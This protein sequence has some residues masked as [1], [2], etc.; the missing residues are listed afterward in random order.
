MNSN[1]QKSTSVR[2]GSLWLA[3]AVVAASVASLT[4]LAQNQ[5]PTAPK[6]APK[7]PLKAAPV[8]ASVRAAAPRR[9]EILFLG[10]EEGEHSTQ[11]AT[12][13]FVPALAKEGINVSW[14]DDVADLTPS[15]LG[16]YD[17]LMVYGDF[18]TITPAEESAV[19]AYVNGGHGLVAIHSAAD[20]FKGTPAWGKLI[21]AQLDRHGPVSDI[22]VAVTQ[23]QHPVV[24]EVTAFD[25]KDEP[26]FFKNA[27]ADR[28]IL[29]DRPEGAG[30]EAV[31]WAR[32]QGKGR[33][34]YTALGHDEPT[35]KNA[36][37]QALIRGAALWTAGDAVSN[38]W[39][40]LQM[41]TVVYKPSVYIPNYERRVPPL[42]F[43]EPLS[44]QDSMKTMQVPPGFEVKLFASEPDIIKPIS[45]NWDERGRLWVVES[46]D[47][48]N[49]QIASPTN[50]NN[51]KHYGAH[52]KIVICEDTNGDGK[53]DK[54][55]TFAEGL[56]IPTGITFWNG[57]V[58]VGQAPQML[59][60]KDT[61]GD[62]K[63]DVRQVLQ[64]GWGLRDTHSG[65][66]N[67]RYGFDNYIWGSIGYSG[68][69]GTTPDGKTMMFS[70]G[71]F[72]MHPDGTGM[73]FMGAF[74][75][76]TWGLGFSETFDL[77]GSTANNTHAV[78][79]GIPPR[80]SADVKGLPLRAGSKKID[81]HYYMAPDTF[82]V[83]QVDVMGGFTAAN[84]F[85]LYTARVY[86]KEYWDRIAFVD[87]PTG[88]VVHRAILEKDGAGYKEK[89]GWNLVASSDE[90]FEPVM[91]AVGPDGEVW[92]EDLYNFI[93]QHNPTPV[94]FDNGDG[95][96]Y[97][98]PLRD[99]THGRIYRIVY[100]GAP[101]AK[102]L[103][104]SKSRPAELVATLSNDN[105]FWRLTAQRLLVERNQKDV[106]PQ[107]LSLAA[108]TKNDSLGLNSGALHALWTL[109]GLGTA[110]GSNPTVTAAVV[111]A[112]KNPA[113]GVRKA[114]LQI[115][116]ANDASLKAIR[117]AGM[118]KDPNPYTRLSAI[119]F[120]TQFHDSD[121]IG[122][123][124]YQLGKAPDVEKD[125]FL[126]M[127]VH[128]AAAHNRPGF[129][130]AMQ[131]DMGATQFK[132][133]AAK[134]AKDEETPKPPPVIPTQT[135]QGANT[136]IPP[137][138][139]VPV[140]EAMMHAY[141]EDI[142][143]PIVRPPANG[144]GR[145]AGAGRGRGPRGTPTG[146]FA[147]DVKISI[148]VAQMTYSVS[149]IDAK[150][151]D[152]IRITLTNNGDVQ[153]N[154]VLIR[155]GSLAT[156]GAQVEAMAHVP[157]AEERSYLPSTPDIMFWM[158]L[159]ETG[160]TGT[161]EFYAPPQPG[162]Y[163]FLCTFPGHWQTMQGV[164]H[165]KN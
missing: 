43:Q 14:A 61:N 44:P 16:K 2:S 129:F 23:P 48:P 51:E 128:D 145:G 132:D 119:L 131:A 36:S 90:W 120:L 64:T 19:E 21:G 24:R 39:E 104:L 83:R 42:K 142:V 55:T 147:E 34:F 95:G 79:V 3:V 152:A 159:V 59:Y 89:D 151:N 112:L 106:V 17:L 98:N 115:L 135:Q 60:L 28:T 10:G 96:A 134:I 100:K 108:T 1:P 154:V 66:G 91:S 69:N 4:V 99:H 153:H 45:M 161:L 130:K 12:S 146:P 111:A 102:I 92:V 138:P 67:L 157:N 136:I 68:F 8:A 31:S 9:I 20:M 118:L 7:A 110:N 29:M 38:Q 70:Q 144:G 155:P 46:V 84:G 97:V 109:E 121:E 148:N 143:G 123:E 63:A 30:R 11:R 37:F 76:N 18:E 81:G 47:Y 163:P 133:Y 125:E 73:E 164:L 140:E 117:A 41:P 124:L 103:S 57:G 149:S 85:N 35:W 150:P 165:V 22:K 58:I 116:P 32:T 65:I 56:N 141:V 127:A 33:V 139:I 156:V 54:F 105:M 6:A 88:R 80:Y 101:P 126:N 162:D 77:F 40:K 122:A 50:P 114:A 78:Y 5:T 160:Q 75:N 87:E 86:P 107:L 158:K 27:D 82:N 49:D 25:T 71:I 62:D 52:D 137:E 94:G 113:A 26:Y 13:L 53:A 72:R 15:N 93:V 74:S